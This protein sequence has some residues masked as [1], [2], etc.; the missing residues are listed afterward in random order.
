MLDEPDEELVEL[1][2]SRVYEKLNLRPER[3]QV[4][5][6]LRGKACSNGRQ[7]PVLQ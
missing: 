6:A 3:A 4:I 5:A 2:G 7:N 1:I